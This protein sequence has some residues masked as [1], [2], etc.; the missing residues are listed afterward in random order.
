MYGCPKVP[1]SILAIPE[2][3]LKQ[4]EIQPVKD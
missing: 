1:A 4:K 3:F 2:S